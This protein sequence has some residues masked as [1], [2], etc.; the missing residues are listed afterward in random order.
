MIPAEGGV[1]Q[2]ILEQ[3]VESCLSYSEDSDYVLATILCGFCAFRD[4]TTARIRKL[5]DVHFIE[6]P[7]MKFATATRLAKGLH[8]PT[9]ERFLRPIPSFVAERFQELKPWEREHEL[10]VTRAELKRRFKITPHRLELAMQTTGPGHFGYPWPLAAL[11]F[12]PTS[13]H[14]PGPLS[15]FATEFKIFDQALRFYR[16][17]D[18]YFYLPVSVAKFRPCGSQHVPLREPLRAWLSR[19]K[20]DLEDAEQHIE[21]LILEPEI[22][23][24]NALSSGAHALTI[25]LTGIRNYPMLPPHA[26]MLAGNVEIIYQKQLSDW[27]LPCLLRDYL[28]RIHKLWLAVLK[29]KADPVGVSGWQHY[30]YGFLDPRPQPKHKIESPSAAWL[31]LGL[32]GRKD[33]AFYSGYHPNFLRNYSNVLLRLA[34]VCEMRVRAFHGHAADALQPLRTFSLNPAVD[35][36][37]TETLCSILADSL[38]L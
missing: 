34:G 3:I 26:A 31:R 13:S 12:S 17:F 36:S 21:A 38:N 33:L 7:V 10:K 15:Y 19:W 14:P 22:H 16:R 32:L 25:L 9:T 37:V 23:W 29:E 8:L 4:I 6:T 20:L 1:S 24:W 2:V 30:C 35:I 28:G 18:P 27:Y 5:G 11:G